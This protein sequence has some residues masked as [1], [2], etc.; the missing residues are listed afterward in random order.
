MQF[1]RCFCNALHSSFRLTETA[2]K[3][4]NQFNLCS[5]LVDLSTPREGIASL[6]E[7]WRLRCCSMLT[8]L[9]VIKVS[10]KHTNN[11]KL[12]L[13]LR[14]VWWSVCCEH[15]ILSQIYGA[16]KKKRKVTRISITFQTQFVF[17][18]L[19]AIPKVIGQ[20]N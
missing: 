5:V 20:S 6:T 3:Q 7:H 13:F 10:H 1:T 4:F 11:F 9:R 16:R 18:N 14:L 2:V 19:S 12:L 17:C 8:H 15:A